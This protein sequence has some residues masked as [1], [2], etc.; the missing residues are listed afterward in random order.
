MRA[1]EGQSDQPVFERVVHHHGRMLEANPFHRWSQ[2]GT[3]VDFAV[4][5]TGWFGVLG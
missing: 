4:G 1:G 2:N 5:S 3:A